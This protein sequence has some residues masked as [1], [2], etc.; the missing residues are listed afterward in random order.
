MKK[1]KKLVLESIV[2]SGR[3][4]SELKAELELKVNLSSRFTV[5]GKYVKLVAKD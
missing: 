4:K 1:L 3:D 2:D 5:D